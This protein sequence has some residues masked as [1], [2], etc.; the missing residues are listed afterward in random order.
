MSVRLFRVSTKGKFG[1][2]DKTGMIVIKPQFIAAGEFNDGLASVNVGKKWGYI[3]A[4]GAIIIDPQ[5]EAAGEFHYSAEIKVSGL[6]CHPGRGLS[7]NPR[8]YNTN[9]L[10]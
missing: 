8:T 9:Q 3:D 2:I 10:R 7:Y 5:L 4:T 1:F 6:H